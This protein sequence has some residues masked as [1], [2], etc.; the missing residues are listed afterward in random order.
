MDMSARQSPLLV[1]LVGQQVS[2]HTSGGAQD[3]KDTGMLDSFDDQ[4]VRLRDDKGK[5]LYLCVSRI[6]LIKPA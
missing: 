1:S 4:W 2:V 6:R 5:Y 3:F